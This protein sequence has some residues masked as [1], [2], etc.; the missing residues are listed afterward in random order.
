MIV[1]EMDASECRNWETWKGA[2][3]TFGYGEGNERGERLL[4]CW[5]SNSLTVMNTAFYQRKWTWGSPDGKNQE[6]D[7]LR[8]GKQ[9]LDE[10]C[11]DVSGLHKTWRGLRPQATNDGNKNQVEA[12]S[13][14]QLGKRLHAEMLCDKM[15]RREYS[16]L[17][18]SKWEQTKEENR[19][20][21]EET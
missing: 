8:S 1:D 9:Q 10:Q 16:T 11:H 5:L 17:L 6:H 7:R 2:I 13:G 18:R 21:V 14:K 20:S 15:V 19:N 3:G 12:Y 4:D